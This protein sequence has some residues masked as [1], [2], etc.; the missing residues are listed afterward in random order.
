MDVTFFLTA[1][2]NLLNVLLAV[3]GLS[4][5]LRA[6]FLYKHL[7]SP[8]LFI[9]GLAMGLVALAAAADFAS[10][11]VTAIAFN[12]DWFLFLGQATSFGFIFLS[13]LNSSE[14]YLR[15]LI[16]WQII[17]ASLILFLLVLAPLL[18]DFPN[19]ATRVLLSGFRALG[20]FLIFGYYA[21]A[22][23]TK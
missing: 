13:L 3:G 20:C 15:R 8:R 21:S 4:I 14:R 6:F 5:S 19:L 10:A 7:R 16:L 1:L 12:A 22:F 18:P 11:F 17:S 9:L 2:P 23:I